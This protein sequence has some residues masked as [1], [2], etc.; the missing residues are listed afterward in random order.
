[1]PQPKPYPN[2]YRDGP[3]NVTEAYRD[4]CKS[5]EAIRCFASYELLKKDLRAAFEYIEPDKPNMDTYSHRT[6]ELLLRACTEV[7]A[8]CKQVFDKNGVDMRGK[9]DIRRYSDLEHPMQLSTYEIACYG[10]TCQDFQPFA[11]FANA[12][13][14]QRSPE[15]YRA[16]NDAKHNRMSKFD[17]ASLWN[18]I[19]AIGAVY[20]LLV[21]Q[22]GPRFDR[23]VHGTVVGVPFM[24]PPDM[25]S[26]RALP[27]WPNDERYEFDWNSLKGTADAYQYHPLPEIP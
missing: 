19:Q 13:R 16:Y 11:A 1:M 25:F 14:D 23:A 4:A 26:T 6:Y 27:H 2:I 3:G 7:E 24:D 22:Y 5:P 18:A 15:W 10:F 20:T 12:I 8:L 9:T 17:R 21:A